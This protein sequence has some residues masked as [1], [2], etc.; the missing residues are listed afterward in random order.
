MPH[1][2]ILGPCRV[3]D[4]GDPLSRI[5]ESYSSGVLKVQDAC[6][7]AAATHLIL[8]AVVVEG[9]L[10]Q[11]FFLLVRQEEDGVLVR[12]HP[13]CAPQKTDGVKRLI[14]L[15]ARRCLQACPGSRVGNTNLTPYLA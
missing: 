12:C 3:R 10:R 7:D 1:V 14:A 4:L 8:E 5:V 6:L 9:Y 2:Q 15:V 11:S 13:F